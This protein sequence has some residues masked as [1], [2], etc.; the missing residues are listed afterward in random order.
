MSSL[1]FLGFYSPWATGK[2]LSHWEQAYLFFYSSPIYFPILISESL[3]T[4]CF[5]SIHEPINKSGID[6]FNGMLGYLFISDPNSYTALSSISTCFGYLQYPNGPIAWFEAGEKFGYQQYPMALPQSKTCNEGLK[7]IK[8]FNLPMYVC[9]FFSVTPIRRVH[10]MHP[11]SH[12]RSSASAPFHLLPI[13]VILTNVMWF[14]Y[15]L[16]H[17]KGA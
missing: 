1:W 14:V 3:E 7:Q 16:C 13:F 6:I 2:S 12:L 11:P 4:S 5:A 8:Q 10:S 9:T 15:H 17:I